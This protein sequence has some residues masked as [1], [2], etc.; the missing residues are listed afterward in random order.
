MLGLGKKNMR[1]AY[2]QGENVLAGDDAWQ[3]ETSG[4]AGTIDSEPHIQF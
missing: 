3:W 2:Y 1:E 4:E